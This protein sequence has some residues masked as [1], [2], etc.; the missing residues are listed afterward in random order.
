[1]IYDLGVLPAG[2]SLPVAPFLATAHLYA[3][4]VDGA[5][6]WQADEGFWLGACNHTRRQ[7]KQLHRLQ[8]AF[9]LPPAEQLRHSWSCSLVAS[10]AGG[11]GGEA[12]GGGGGSGGGGGGEGGGGEGGG[13]GGGV[14]GR[15]YLTSSSLIFYA[16]GG[17]LLGRE[18]KQLVRLEQLT[19][20][21]KAKAA[22][23]RSVRSAAIVVAVADVAGG[24]GAAGAVGGA[25]GGAGRMQLHAFLD[26][27]RTHTELL[28]LLLP[29]MPHLASSS[30]Q[31]AS[32]AS[33][34]RLR[35][36]GLP[37]SEAPLQT[38]ALALTLTLTPT[39]T[40]TLTLTRRRCTSSA[41]SSMASAAGSA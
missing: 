7:A 17:R 30:T 37:P 9:G 10:A 3:W 21:R 12:A 29:A 24:A 25:A 6:A 23:V 4:P 2:G 13:G 14:A 15:L 28:R 32:S 8:L 5:E 36:L 38:L 34:G 22:G 16:E 40:P 27:N 1:V 31:R 39:P 35:R 19:A 26:R 41:A 20:L 33:L 11:F 18:V